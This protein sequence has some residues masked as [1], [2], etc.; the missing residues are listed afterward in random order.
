M[1]KPVRIQLIRKKRFNLREYS[2]KI[3][4]LECI[5]VSRPTKWGNPFKLMGDMVYVD[6]GYRRKILDK[7]V[8]LCGGDNETVVQLYKI[9]LTGNIPDGY[10]D[11]LLSGMPDTLYLKDYFRTLDLSELKVKNLA[12]WCAKDKLCHADILLKLANK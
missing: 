3:N 6:A 11:I 1:N 2:K 12:C 7:W 10:H 9:M 5:V 4:G 8:Y